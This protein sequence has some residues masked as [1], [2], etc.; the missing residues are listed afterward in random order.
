MLECSS[1]LLLTCNDDVGG[2]PRLCRRSPPRCEASP[3]IDGRLEVNWIITTLLTFPLT[4]HCWLFCVALHEHRRVCER[5]G[6]ST[7]GPHFQIVRQIL[8]NYCITNRQQERTFFEL[9]GAA[10]I[11]KLEFMSER[12]DVAFHFVV[13]AIH[14]KLE[15]GRKF[16][17]LRR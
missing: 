10:G 4:P 13:D 7:C 3:A 15:V 12:F 5:R 2:R 8:K 17:L 11:F 6:R 9:K 1:S 14:K 16:V